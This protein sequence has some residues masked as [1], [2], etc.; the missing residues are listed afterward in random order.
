VTDAPRPEQ[1]TPV[2]ILTDKLTAC[3]DKL[4]L[5]DPAGRSARPNLRPVPDADALAAS[6]TFLLHHDYRVSRAEGRQFVEAT[7]D[8]NPIHREGNVV[9]GAMTLSKTLLPVEVLMPTLEI[10][11]VHIKLTS[12]AFYG[13]RTRTVLRLARQGSGRWRGD[14][15]TYQSGRLVAKS[16]LEGRAR[17]MLEPS[18]KVWEW[19]VNKQRL[20]CV[21]RFCDALRVAPE[22]YLDKGSFRDYTYPLSFVASLPSGA[23]VEQMSGSGG[24]LN[25]LRFEFADAAKVPIVGRT[26]PSV[27]LEQQRKRPTFNKILANVVHGIMTYCKGHAIVHPDAG[28]ALDGA[29]ED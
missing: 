22:A 12:V 17:A 19:R 25:S 9:A 3:G 24:L 15:T 27:Q 26:P 18:A 5:R 6:G 16:T 20:D 7:G 10:L 11:S 14:S 29:G 13:D 4:F 28:L 1:A 2:R 23:I 21:K 8:P